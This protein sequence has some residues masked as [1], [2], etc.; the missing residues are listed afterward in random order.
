MSVSE[1]DRSQPA[2]GEGRSGQPDGALPG[3]DGGA[4]L[5]DG[6][7]RGAAQPRPDGSGSASASAEP[8]AERADAER[9]P[10]GGE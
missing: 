6:A 4:V 9:G 10:E 2:G 1:P 5:P 8:D 3:P 7:R